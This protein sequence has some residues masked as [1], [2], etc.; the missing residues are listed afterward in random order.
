MVETKRKETKLTGKE[1][2]LELTVL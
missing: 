2:R 1:R